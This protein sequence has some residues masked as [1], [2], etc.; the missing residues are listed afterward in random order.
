MM[1][2]AQDYST[3]NAIGQYIKPILSQKRIKLCHKYRRNSILKGYRSVTTM[4]HLTLSDH[5][6]IP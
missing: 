5:T 3:T 2:L 1:G 4:L 6:Y